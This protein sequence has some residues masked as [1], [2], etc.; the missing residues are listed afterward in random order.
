MRSRE[1]G[2]A[3]AEGVLELIEPR[4]GA[5]RRRRD[6]LDGGQGVLDAMVKLTRE[7]G[8]ALLG[9]VAAHCAQQPDAQALGA[10]AQALLNLLGHAD[11]A[12]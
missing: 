7:E 6:G 11:A 12:A 2:D 9:M 5:R 3:A 1:R 8:L 4:R 10:R